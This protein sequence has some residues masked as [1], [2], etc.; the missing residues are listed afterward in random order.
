MRFR[1]DD[2]AQREAMA[3]EQV[4]RVMMADQNSENKVSN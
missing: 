3:K 1:V 4:S 2:C